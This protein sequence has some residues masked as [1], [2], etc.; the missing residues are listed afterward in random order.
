MG[1]EACVHGRCMVWLQCSMAMKQSLSFMNY[2]A[3][4]NILL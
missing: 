4:V 2:N 1:Y 3:T